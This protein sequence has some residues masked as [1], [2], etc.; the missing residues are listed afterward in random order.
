MSGKKKKRAYVN[1]FEP[2]LPLPLQ[3]W[4]K[5]IKYGLVKQRVGLKI[6]ISQQQ[7]GFILDPP[8]SSTHT[9]HRQQ[10]TQASKHRTS[11]EADCFAT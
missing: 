2:A 10:T 7:S 5:Y 1:L 11:Y 6:T 3:V 4:C 9:L 8:A